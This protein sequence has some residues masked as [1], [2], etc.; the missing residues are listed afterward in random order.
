MGKLIAIYALACSLAVAQYSPPSG[1]GTSAAGWTLSGSTISAGTN[2]VRIGTTVLDGTTVKTTG[3]TGIGPD[4]EVGITGDVTNRVAIGLNTSDIPRLSFGPGSGA[5]DLF[6]E[7]LGAASLRF[8]APD[9]AAPV[10][11]TL[12]VQNVVAGTS[13]TAGAAL[14]INGSRGTGTGLGGIVQFQTAPAGSTGT[15]QNALVTAMTILGSGNVGIGTVAPQAPLQVGPGT[16]TPVVGSP[17]IYLTNNGQTDF[18]IRDSSNDVEGRWT[19]FSGGV[20]IG[21]VSASKLSFRTSNADKMTIDTAGNVGIGTTSPTYLLDVA[22]SGASG[23]LRVKDQTATTGATRV[24]FDL[25]AA[26]ALTTNIFSVAGKMTATGGIVLPSSCT[27]LS[28]GVLYNNLGVPAI[29]P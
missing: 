8:G 2:S 18:S 22:K 21:S 15:S 20:V 14:K 12:S 5:R 17:T 9:A 28:S 1:G 11:Q 19:A 24:L 3:S 29:C 23:T 7:R 6:L 4:F 10:G 27:G 26:D 16:D 13:N 25:G